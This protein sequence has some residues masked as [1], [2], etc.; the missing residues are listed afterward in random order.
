MWNYVRTTCTQKLIRIF[1]TTQLMLM[2]LVRCDDLL[3]V[4]GFSL[5]PR[6]EKPG[7]EASVGPTQLVW[8]ENT[9]IIIIGCPGIF[10]HCSEGVH[11]NNVVSFSQNFVA[12]N[13]WLGD[14]LLWSCIFNCT[15]LFRC[16]CHCK[17]RMWNAMDSLNTQD[18][19]LIQYIS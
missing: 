12:I 5:F 6:P 3:F 2:L 17:V 16:T 4:H 8:R 10:A 15:C 1:K 14:C 11:C 9:A 19:I 18:T 13:C 7:K